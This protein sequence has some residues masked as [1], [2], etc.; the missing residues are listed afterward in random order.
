MKM[1]QTRQKIR[2]MLGLHTHYAQVC[3]RLRA[4]IEE[5]IKAKQDKLHADWAKI[6]ADREKVAESLE[7]IHD[8][9]DAETEHQEKMG[10][11]QKEMKEDI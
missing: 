8:K 10:T 7:D 3:T 9:P 11:N 6:D 4:E 2:E 1:E 5:D